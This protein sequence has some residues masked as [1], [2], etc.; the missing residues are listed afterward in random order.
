LL[1]RSSTMCPVTSGSGP[2]SSRLT[3]RRA[4]HPSLL[5]QAGYG[6]RRPP[7]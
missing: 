4:G 5:L 6:R 1:S 2:A 3:G 7:T